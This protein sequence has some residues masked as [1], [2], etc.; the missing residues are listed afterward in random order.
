MA[1]RVRMQTL[2]LGTTALSQGVSFW[3]AGSELLRSK[4]L[5]RN[6]YDSGDWFNVLDYGYRTNGFA[7]GLPPR[8]DNESK[9]G[10]MRPAA[11]R[12]RP[13]PRHPGRSGVPGR[14]RRTCSRSGAAARCSGWA[15]RGWWSRS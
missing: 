7:R 15:A 10:Y 9:W 13:R 1:D 5:D 3:L 14:W 11:R 4:S 2:A 8:A 12:P 6:S